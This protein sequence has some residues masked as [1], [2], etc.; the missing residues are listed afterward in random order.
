MGERD[1]RKE[2]ANTKHYGNSRFHG[3]SD[4]SGLWVRVV[5][6]Q[7]C[8]YETIFF[9]HYKMENHFFFTATHYIKNVGDILIDPQLGQN[10][11]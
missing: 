2:P 11:P 1:D 8:E 4:F 6:H 9:F 7:E 5:L 3:N 10:S